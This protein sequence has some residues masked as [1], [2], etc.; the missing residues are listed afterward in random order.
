MSGGRPAA[1]A[2][3][4]FVAKL[5]HASGVT[6]TSI[7]VLRW[8]SAASRRYMFTSSTLPVTAQKCS[9]PE[10]RLS[11]IAGW[12][13]AQASAISVNANGSQEAGRTEVGNTNL[14]Q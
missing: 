5:P 11:A 2:A 10:A 9:G 13:K 14:R 12:Q 8:K 1:I 3:K 6:S 4:Y 7:P